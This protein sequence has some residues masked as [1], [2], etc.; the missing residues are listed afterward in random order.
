MSDAANNADSG[1]GLPGIGDLLAMFGAPNI[2]GGVTKSIEQF[3][4]GINDFLV[5]V[6]T[7]NETMKALNGVAIRVSALLDDVEEPIRA[8]V[9]QMT[10][11]IKAAD[12][13]INQLSTLG[14]LARRLQPLVQMAEN[15][16][17]LF[18]LGPL[19][20]MLGGSAPASPSLPAAPAANQPAA[21]N[22]PKKAAAKKPPAT[23]ASPKAAAKKR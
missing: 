5:A 15:A 22:A 9:P 17:S 23:K 1:S 4:R 6:E 20:A 21:Q 13:T 11:T 18:G 2:F 7:F 8:S 16:G 3:K 10:R 12:A 14:D 19:A